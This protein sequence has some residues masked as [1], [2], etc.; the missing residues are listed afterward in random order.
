MSRRKSKSKIK[1]QTKAIIHDHD[2]SN[3]FDDAHMEQPQT[4][5]RQKRQ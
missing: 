2:Y 4:D 1:P 5:Q 3:M